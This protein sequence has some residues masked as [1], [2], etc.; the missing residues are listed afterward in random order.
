MAQEKIGNVLVVDDE[1]GIRDIVKKCLEFGHMKVTT[2]EDGVEA[3]Q[4]L[5]KEEFDVVLSDI[6]M[7]RMDGLALAG[8]VRRIRPETMIL[9]MTGYASVD[10][11]VE[12]IKQGV[13]DYIV[14]PFPNMQVVQQAV[15]RAIERKHL[16]HDK[17]K[18]IEE[19]RRANEELTYHRQL[20]MEKVWKTDRELARRIDRLSILYEISRS[21]SSPI[22]L[23]E[24]L[25]AITG[26]V[27]EALKGATVVLWLA[28][29]A[30]GRLDRKAVCGSEHPDDIPV[31]FDF[32][33]GEIGETLQSRRTRI[34]EVGAIRDTALRALGENERAGSVVLSPISFED[35]ALGLYTVFLD[36]PALFTDD[37]GSMLDSIADQTSVTITNSRLYENQ[38]RLFRE[39]IEA[40][41]TAIDSR[42]HYTGGHSYMVTQYA[43]AVGGELKFDEEKLE[44]VRV[45]G[46]LHD[47]GKIGI[48]DA[49]LNKPG[50]LDDAEMAVIKSHP[51]LGRMII[52]SIE[53]LKPA[54]KIIYHHHE[55]YDGSGYPDGIS[56]EAIPLESRILQVADIFHALTSDRIYRKAMGFEKAIS[57]I[58]DEIGTVIDPEVGM[59][60][61]GLVERGVIQPESSSQLQSA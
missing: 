60:F 50:K 6:S 4:C 8:E 35:K 17:K 10:S 1:P 36:D 11:A 13:F 34:R 45:A 20:L 56:G 24:R 29:G 19:L 5:Q 33:G 59:I 49:I 52:E 28:D 23:E 39:T 2:A 16:L 48:G 9:L 25:V 53:A 61:L 30:G 38:Q 55:H 47:I 21:A 37:D 12:A 32:D 57:I 54:A 43:L 46:L 3:L 42:D 26:K 44:L 31:R 14:K 15:G 22:D 41:A 18:L 7:P 27:S 58:R 40:L 51:I